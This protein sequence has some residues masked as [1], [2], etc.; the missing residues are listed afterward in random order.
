MQ[1]VVKSSKAGENS[2]RVIAVANSKGGSGKTATV[3]NLGA[4]LARRG[5]KVLLWDVDPQ[6][7]LTDCFKVQYPAHQIYTDDALAT[8]K[9]DV[10]QAPVQ[11]A[12]NLSIIPTTKALGG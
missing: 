3:F 8:E 5:E 4:E 12:D 1:T 9:I 10:T 6:A 7:S 11:V 2:M